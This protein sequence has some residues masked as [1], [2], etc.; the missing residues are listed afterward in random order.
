MV[1]QQ[2]NQAELMST[3]VIQQDGDGE[4]F[5]VIPDDIAADMDLKPGDDI[6]WEIDSPADGFRHPTVTVRKA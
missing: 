2:A 6:V 5:I 4:F 3:A 1:I